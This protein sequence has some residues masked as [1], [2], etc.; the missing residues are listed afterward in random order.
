[1]HNKRF[2]IF[3]NV[4]WFLL[5]HFKNYLEKIISHGY[6]VTVITSNTGKCDQIKELG[7][8]VIEIDLNRGY[9]NIISEIKSFIKT[10]S[11]IKKLS[12]DIIELITIKPV[13]YGGI[14]SRLLGINKTIYYMSGLGALFT[15]TSR[16]G[17]IKTKIISFLY[18]LIMRQHSASIIVENNDDK[19]IFSSIV[20]NV[21]DRI[22]LVPGVGIDLNK[23]F[24]KNGKSDERIRVGLASRLLSDKGIYEY[25][26]AV[27]T[28]KYDW[29]NVEFVLVG[30]IDKTNPA[31]LTKADCEKI[32]KESDVI[33]MEHI[34]DMPNF[35]RTL[36]I[37]VLP[38]YREGFP[39][40]I[41]EASATGVPVITTDVT[42]CRSAVIDNFT[43]IIVP[44]KNSKKLASAI[45]KL[46][47]K[48]SERKV[49]AKNARKHAMKEFGNNKLSMLHINTWLS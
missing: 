35:L 9:K 22:H 40:V 46:L 47:S 28:L 21:E 38:S 48:E 25:L 19:E 16:L 7:I 14:I 36:S 11:V 8:D 32:S 27:R 45:N 17:R 44:P 37:F 6:Q 4:D 30:S 43:G 5:S 10:Y 49:L 13:I 18:S 24:P 1:M 2:C 12:P 26:A 34:D 3:I 20:K 41:M 15:N 39:K 31:S 23:F 29:P 33:L 42:G